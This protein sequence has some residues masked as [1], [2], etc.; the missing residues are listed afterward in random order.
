MT[1]C[2][3]PLVDLLLIAVFELI[4]STKTVLLL[5]VTPVRCDAEGSQCA[6]R[7]SGECVSKE[8]A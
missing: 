2:L 4:P 7:T 1:P 6:E 3:L 8:N 5:V